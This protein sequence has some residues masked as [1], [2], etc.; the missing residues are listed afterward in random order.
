M[1][2]SNSESSVSF[3]MLRACRKSITAVGVP[4]GLTFGLLF[5][6][7]FVYDARDEQARIRW[8]VYCPRVR[9]EEIGEQSESYLEMI[10]RKFIRTLSS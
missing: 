1:F 5:K 7:R 9:E 10:V 6:S 8:P 2:I 3:C 4:Q